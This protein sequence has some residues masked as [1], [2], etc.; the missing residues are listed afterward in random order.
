MNSYRR[1]SLQV[2]NGNNVVIP[3]KVG[4]TSSKVAYYQDEENEKQLHL[5]LDLADEVRMDTEHMVVHYKNLMTKHHDTMVK[6]RQFK[7]GD[8]VLKR[9]SSTT[10]NPTHGKLRPNWERLYRVINYKR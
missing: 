5:S 7:I 6:H 1:N 10:K 9:M 4:L 3:T 2:S 8:L